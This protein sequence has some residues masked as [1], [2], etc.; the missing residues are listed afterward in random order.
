MTRAIRGGVRV[1]ANTR[2][3]IASATIAL[4]GAVMERNGLRPDDIEALIFTMTA[5]L[6]A[7]IPPLVIAEQGVLDAPCLCMAEPRWDGEMPYV[8]RVLVFARRDRDE[9]VEH[10]YLAGASAARP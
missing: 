6:T 9:P 5:D 10:V 7:D 2:E 1:D 4:V 3:A 8:I